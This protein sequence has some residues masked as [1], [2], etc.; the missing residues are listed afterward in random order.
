MCFKQ[1]Y[2]FCF[3]KSWQFPANYYVIIFLKDISISLSLPLFVAKIQ[4]WDARFQG[5]DRAQGLFGR[6]RNRYRFFPD[7]VHQALEVFSIDLNRLMNLVNTFCGGSKAYNM[8]DV[9]I[10]ALF[11][12]P[13]LSLLCLGHVKLC[14]GLKRL[15]WSSWFAKD[16]R[17]KN[18]VN[19]IHTQEYTFPRSY[20]CILP[21]SY[22]YNF[23][24]GAKCTRC[25]QDNIK[26]K[27]CIYK[28][29]ENKW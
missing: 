15:N 25:L 6:Y 19:R 16:W 18:C 10:F 27:R 5:R 13:R 22:Y 14:Q 20:S 23:N 4:K 21:H 8:Q 24:T 17:N 9:T 12:L 1:C 2:F 11:C 29:K 26:D 3:A 28:M 7:T